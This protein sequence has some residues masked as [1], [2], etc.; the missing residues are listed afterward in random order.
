MQEMPSVARDRQPDHSIPPVHK[1][2]LREYLALVFLLCLLGFSF[3]GTRSLWGTDE[4]RYV[5]NAI[6]MVDS[7]NYLVPAY[8]PDRVNFSKPPMTYWVIAASMQVMGRSTWAVRTPYAL[9]FIF[10]ALLIYA[11]GKRLVPDRP[12][13]AP[14]IYALSVAPFFSA[15]VINTDVLLTCF[16]TLAMFGFVAWH[17]DT[18]SPP[19]K[20]YLLLM[21]AGFGLAFLTKGPPGLIPLLG[22]VPFL[23]KRQGWKGVL[24]LFSPLGLLVFL[25]VGMTWYAVVVARYPWVL[26]Y[27]IHYEIYDRIFTTVQHRNGQW[28]GWI[29]VYLPVFLLGT[30]PWWPWSAG[31]AV[32]CLNRDSLKSMYA[33]AGETLFLVLW[34]VVPLLVFILAKSRL[35]L[36][37]LPLFIPIS[38]LIARGLRNRVNPGSTGQRIAFVIWVV[39]L[40]G[41]KGWMSIHL[42][43]DRDN[44]M[45]AQSLERTVAHSRYDAMAFVENTADNGAIEEHTPWGIR[46]YIDKPIYGI[47]WRRPGIEPRVCTLRSRYPSIIYA[48][49]NRLDLDKFNAG[50]QGCSPAVTITKLGALQHWT[51][52]LAGRA[53]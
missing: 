5:G 33:R 30:L 43:S 49:D 27:F 11:M 15:N 50:L 22:V 24:R 12:W 32:A 6:Q 40:I 47:P 14:L 20:G 39:V 2:R 25:V 1:G 37:V 17:W 29:V 35:P 34:I 13:L 28:Y 23:A 3:Q 45:R 16:E 21:W 36:Y 42:H 44:K 8:S 52:E 7:G 46:F 48:I 51:L 38:L 18:H 53:D 10:T 31:K 26:H 19:R 4:G 41:L 9:A